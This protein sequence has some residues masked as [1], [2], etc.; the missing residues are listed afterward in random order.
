[1]DPNLGQTYDRDRNHDVLYLG[2]SVIG[3]LQC[4]SHDE[5]EL[6]VSEILDSLPEFFFPVFNLFLVGS[7]RFCVVKG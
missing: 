6:E 7:S 4:F 1:M 2:S 5:S 3:K